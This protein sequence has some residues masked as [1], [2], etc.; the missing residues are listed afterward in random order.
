MQFDIFHSIGRIDSIK[1]I[2]PDHTIYREFFRQCRA[3]EAMGYKTIW[4][5]ESHFSSEVQK[6]NPHPVIPHY[7]GEVG[8]N[9]DTCQVAQMIFGQTKSI[10]FGSAIM[11]IVGGNGGPIATADRVGMLTFLNELLPTPRKLDIG[12]AA[13]RFPYINRPFGIL[14]R[15]EIEKQLWDVYQRFIFLEA[16]EIFLRLLHGET[17]SS[18]DIQSWNLSQ[19]S[20]PE[21]QKRLDAMVALHGPDAAKYAPRW[22]FDPLKLIPSLSPESLGRH[23]QLVIGSHDPIA[24]EHALKFADVGIFNLSFTPPEQIGK[25]HTGMAETR[26]K[27]GLSDWKRHRMPRTVLTFIDKNQDI[28]KDRASRCLD[29]YIEAMRQTV[30]L[31]PKEELLSRALVGTPDHICEQLRGDQHGF[32]AD[33]RLMLWFEFNQTD[34]DGIVEQ[35][36]LFSEKVAPQ[37]A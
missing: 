32:H 33:D 34:H 35:M 11:N 12:F 21:T 28:A 23:V 22:T 16:T 3:A 2:P 5:A 14:P 15:N 8:L 37:F 7:H 9:A 17:I 6:K 25:V 1:P 30:V 19:G 27:M 20:N 4:V 18:A 26:K 36:K 24:R 31:P 10:G 29:I 13:G